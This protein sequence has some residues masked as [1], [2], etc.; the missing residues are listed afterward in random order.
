MVASNPSYAQDIEEVFALCKTLDSYMDILNTKQDQNSIEQ[1]NWRIKSKIN[2]MR[3]G[4]IFAS[5]MAELVYS[6][7]LRDVNAIE[8]C[9]KEASKISPLQRDLELNYG[10]GLRHCGMFQKSNNVFL[11]YYNATC[12]I[13]ALKELAKGY[14]LTGQYKK[15]LNLTTEIKKLGIEMNRDIESFAANCDIL[16]ESKGLD[17]EAVEKYA[18]NLLDF[19][20][21]NHFQNHKFMNQIQ[22]Q[23]NES[24]ILY[25]IQIDANS[26]ELS[27]LNENFLDR[28]IDL[29]LPS[30]ILSNFVTRFIA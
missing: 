18:S 19:I 25:S 5:N 17:Y 24:W 9:Y 22:S 20:Y 11:K 27:A 15:R 12:S 7:S 13:D 21:E 23:G 28:V 8:R 29:D 10:L 4:D 6:S 1:L 16:I 26:E 14:E 30:N 3:K 2:A